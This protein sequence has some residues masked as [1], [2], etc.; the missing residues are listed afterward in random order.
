MT[1]ST[2]TLI[3]IPLLLLSTHPTL[4]IHALTARTIRIG[5][6][7]SKL[8]LTQAK[9]LEDA[10]HNINTELVHIDAAGDTKSQDG[11]TPTQM[12]PL[13][14]GEV[15]FTGAL[16]AAVLDGSVDVA[17]HSQKDIPPECRWNDVTTKDEPRLVI[18]ACLGP[19][20]T[21]QD[22]LITDDSSINSI[23]TLPYGARVGSA[24]IRRQAQLKSIRSDLNIINIRGNV[25]ARLQALDNGEVDGLILAMAGFTS[26]PTYSN[27]TGNT[28]CQASIMSV[29]TCVRIN[30]TT[31]TSVGVNSRPSILA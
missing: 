19:R 26:E 10:L 5:T 14:V 18:G 23:Q 4:C 25:D 21:P 20:E 15:D 9:K 11:K 27:S 17:V 29:N 30:C 2:T 3:G 16:D 12:L 22:V 13:A 31:R 8:A 1:A 28:G 7:S 24:S 6:R